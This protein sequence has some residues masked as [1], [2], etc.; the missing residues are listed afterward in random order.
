[1]PLK[2]VAL[3]VADAVDPLAAAVGAANTLV[4]GDGWTAYNTDVAGIAAALRE[5]GVAGP[6]SAVVLGAGGTAQAAL[7]ALGTLGVRDPIVLVRDLGR[8]GA[9]RETAARLGLAPQLRA[10]LPGPVPDADLVV[11]TLPPGAADGLR[12]ARHGRAR[13]GLRALAHPVRGRGPPG[14]GERGQRAGDAAAPGRGPGRADDRPGR[15]GRGDA[16]RAGRRR[17]SRNGEAPAPAA[18]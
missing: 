3:A 18:P 14:R 17:P 6:R 1:M 4:L 9:L 2:R 7:A 8:A 5:G 15:A 10:G 12:G 13:R 11:S 16:L